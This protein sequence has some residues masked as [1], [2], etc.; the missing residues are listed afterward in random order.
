MM[1]KNSQGCLIN[2]LQKIHCKRFHF[3][4]ILRM[5]YSL[6]WSFFVFIIG[7]QLVHTF[8]G[9]GLA[10]ID[11][12]V[13]SVA[14]D[15]VWIA[16]VVYMMLHKRNE[17]SNFR[18]QWKVPIL[19]LFV[20]LLR[21]FGLSM[22]QGM[23]RWS[24]AVWAKYDLYPLVVLMSGVLVWTVFFSSLIPFVSERKIEMILWS[25]LAWWLLRQGM[26]IILP[27]FFSWFGYGPIG[28]YVLGSAPPVRYRTGPGW[29]MRLQWLFSWPNN[30]GFFLVGVSGL[31]TLLFLKQPFDRRKMLFWI[32]Y[33]GSL[34]R[35]L[36]RGARIGAWVGIA[37]S[38]WF[39]F[40]QYKKLLVGGVVLC[41][42]CIIGISTMKTWSTSGHW[43]ALWEWIHAFL[44]QPWWYGLGMAWP[45]VHYEWVY[46]PENQ[47][48]QILLDI[49]LPWLLLRWGV[50]RIVLSRARALRK[51]DTYQHRL[52]VV[53]LFGIC[54]LL[55]EWL[56]LHVREDSMV[57]Y[58]ILWT[59]G[60]VLWWQWNI[61]GRDQTKS[62]Q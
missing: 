24:I 41:I 46:L 48:M 34:L 28:D 58:L 51:N 52:V 42:L 16:L 50:V 61:A 9:Y 49:G 43:I 14:K 39:L 6:L 30:Y 20:V 18:R 21:S 32:L 40:P 55:I 12:A 5:L 3:C 56:F 15:V 59:F 47:Y 27:D 10:I 26:K 2:S 45:S 36:S 7:Y 17:L 8:F 53:S 35:T 38:I 19:L 33:W 54:W 13:F 25:I 37:L 62:I 44:A 60:I 29:M 1:I 22:M 31:V 23:S 11:P 4:Y 57:N